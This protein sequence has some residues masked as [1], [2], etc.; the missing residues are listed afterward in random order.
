[1]AYYKTIDGYKYDG[2]LLELADQL[3]QGRGDGVIYVEGADKLIE[4]Y[5]SADEVS[6]TCERTI[7]WIKEYYKWDE[8]ALIHFNTFV[9]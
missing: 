1:M 5:Y 8:E 2:E 6:E 7:E 3:T 9:I 4:Q